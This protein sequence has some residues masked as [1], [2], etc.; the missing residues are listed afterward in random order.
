MV[1]PLIGVTELARML[2]LS[3]ADVWR[4][5]HSPGFPSAAAEHWTAALVDQGHRGMAGSL[6]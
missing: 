6:L 5:A 2:D 4:L 1:S 3:G